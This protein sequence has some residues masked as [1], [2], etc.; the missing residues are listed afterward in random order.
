[1]NLHPKP[2]AKAEIYATPTLFAEAIVAK[3]PENIREPSLDSKVGLSRPDENHL[4]RN[5]GRQSST[6]NF[7]GHDTIISTE[8]S[9]KDEEPIYIEFGEGDQR[10]PINF[11]KRK[12]WA[13]TA[14]GCFATYL[15]SSASS[16]YNMGFPS[17]IRDLHC[18]EFQ[19][20]IGLSVYALGFGLT[21][22]V[23]ASFSEEFGRLPLYIGSGLGFLLMSPM[24]AL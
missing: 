8:K 1:M 11:S 4:D 16:I 19:A 20:T 14:I 24:I 2:H 15:L 17:M 22:L 10:N 9:F 3:S 23:T 21:P 12:K 13:I 5:L 18:T 7:H 6:L